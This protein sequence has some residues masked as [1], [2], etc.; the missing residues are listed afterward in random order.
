MRRY[1]IEKQKSLDELVL[2]YEVASQ[3]GTV[4]F[5][6]E[7][8]FCELSK[9]FGDH[10]EMG[11]AHSVLT[12]GL[13]LHPESSELYLRRAELLLQNEQFAE[14][15]EWL[16]TAMTVFPDDDG[17][18]FLF[19]AEAWSKLKKTDRALAA[20]RDFREAAPNQ[21]VTRESQSCAMLF[22]QLKNVCQ[23]FRHLQ[24]TLLDEPENEEALEQLW[25]CVEVSGEHEESVRLHEH[26][27]DLNP[28]SWRAWFNLG[29][30]YEGLEEH[31]AALE[32]Y[33]YAYLI[34]PDFKL[35]YEA[36]ASLAFREEKFKFALRAYQEMSE[37]VEPEATTFVRIGECYEKMGDLRIACAFYKQAIGQDAA[38]AEANFRL[39]ECFLIEKKVELAADYF[40]KAVDL[41]KES[42][43]YHA[44]LAEVYVLLDD[45]RNAKRH[46]K[47][48]TNLAPDETK[49]WIQF[50]S[51]LMQRGE[52]DGA[53]EVLEDA[54]LNSF[55]IELTYCRA[56]CLFLMKNRAD[57]FDALGDAL[58]DDFEMH[59]SLFDLAPSLL[60][61][62]EVLGFIA[63]NRPEN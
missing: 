25:L 1:L 9:Y 6:E 57:A 44:A 37:R 12:D 36:F 7:T 5:F 26:L 33:E 41:K 3:G 53:F 19:R 11:K 55:G 30:A 59:D 18:K 47:K 42:D 58:A 50:A 28:Y 23:R 27:I 40:K 32:A 56:A 13:T 29:T 17:L 21:T 45:V 51:F 62:S 61:D 20:L 60:N 2:E 52:F 38:C 49:T 31:D 16:E 15:G 54:E 35:A 48:A 24:N 8:V 22:E 10:Q 34:R 14:A 63:T 39:G 4:P 43:E 46:F